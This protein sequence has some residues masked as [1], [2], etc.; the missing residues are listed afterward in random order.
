MN[1]IYKL[2][3][4]KRRNELVVVS[5]ITAGMGKEK[6]T[7]QLADLVALSP[8]RKLLGTLTPV[9]LLTGLIAGLLPAMAL[10]ADLPTGGQI[11]GGQGSI[12]TSGNQMTIHQQTQNMAANWHSFDIGKNNTVQ[13][14]Q[15]NSSSVALNR[16]TGASGSQIMGTLK[17]NGQVFI[18]NPNGVL[19]GKNARVDVGGL[20]ASTKNI[21]T[22][23]FMK[24]Q[25]TLSGSGNPGA[26]VVNQGSLTTSKGGYIVLAGER[27]SNSGTVTTPSGKTILAAGK[28]VT[29]QLDNGGLTSVSVNGSVVNALVENQGLISA[30]NGQVYLTAKGQDMLLNTVVNNSGTVEAKGLANRGGEIVLN[31]GDSGVVSQSGHLLADSQTGQGGK[32]TLE[33]QNI[34]LAGGSLTTATG[35]TGGG[36]VYV[37]GGW[38]GQDSHIKNASKVVM[39]KAATVDVSATENGNGGTAVLWS[40]DYTNFR[41]TVLAK[42]GAKSGDGGRVETSSHRN[43]QAS[44]AVDASARAGHGGEW[45]LDP[46]DVTIVGAGADTGIDSATADGT[47]IF[48]PTA[49]GGQILNSSIVNQL[50]AGTSVTVKTSGTDTDGETGN[51][52]VNANI[53]KTAGTD[54]KL[55]LLADNNIST[56]DNVSIGATTGKLN[57]DLLAGNT[58]NNASISLGKFINISLNGGDLLADAGNSASGVS[59][60]FMNNGKIKGGNVTLNLS[61]GLGGY[62]YNV[63][64]DNDLTINGSVTGSTGWGAV[65]GFTAGGKLAMN[66]PGSISLQANDPGNGG[67]RVLISG[68]KGVTLNAAAGTVTLNAAKAA[69]N[70]VNIT[71]GNGAVSITNMVQDGSNGMTLTNANISS[72]DGIVLN[73]TTF[74]GQAVVMSGVNLT[75]GGDVD[76]T[77]LA[78]NLTTGGLGAASSSGVQLSG[79]NISST[80]GNITLTGTAGT[81]V[82]HP[83]ISSLQVSNS[84]FTT[85]NALTLNGTTETTTGVKVTGSTLSAAT[86]NVNGVARVQGTG[87]SLATSQLLGGLADLTNVSLSSAG[88]AAGAQNVLDNSIV[89]DANRD[90]L[91]A[92]RIEN[93]TSV[94][95]NGTA[96]FDD[97]AKS[98]KGWTHDYSSVDTPNGGWIF[99]NTSVTAGGDVN[100]KGVAFTNA[101]VTVSNGSL[102]LDN[103]GAVPLTGTTVT[104]N[105]GAV[106]VHSGGGNIDL[107]K[108]NISAKRDITLKTDNG[109]VLI[110]GAN[111]TVKAN[112]TSSDGD[113]MITGN[114]GTSMGVRLVNANLTSIN[115]SI[116]GSAIG[117]SNDDMASFGAVSLFGAD[118]FH[119]ANTGHGEMNG[120]VN[121]YLDLTRNGAI[122]IGQIFAG[123]DTNVVFDGSFDIKGDAFTTGAKPS[124]TYDIFFN[125]GSSSITFKGG[126]SSLTSCSH[127]VYTRFSAYS[128]THTTNFILDGADFVFNVTAGT[129]PHQG[130]SMLGT[131]EFNKYTSGFAFSGNGNAQLNI[132]TSSQEEG[133]Y[134]NR[135]TNKDLLG[136][137]SLNVTNDIGDAIVMLGHTAVNLVNATITGT[138]GT[139]AG[140]RLESTDKSNVS[141]GNNTITGISKTGSGIK[142]IGNNITLSN[143]TLNGT[144]GNGSGVVLTGGSNYTLDGAS[145][146]GT[147]AAGSGIAVNGTLTVNNGTVVKGLATGGGNGVTVSGDLVTDSGDGIS[148]SGTASSGDGI[149]VDGDTTL[150]NA[151]LNGGADS[152]VGVNIAGNLTTDSSTQVS[153]HADSG[154]GVNL[155]AALTGASVK[156]SSDT[157]TGVQLADNAVVT[158]AV[159]NG[160][161]ASGDGVTFTGNVKMDDTSAAKLNASSTSGT[162]LKLADNANVSI[163]TITKVTQEKKD[164]DG[165]PVLDA[166]GNPETE[167]ITTQAPVTTPVTLTGTSE[168]GS[169]I[170]TEGNVSISGI[171]LNGSTTADTGTGVSLGGNL[172]IADD[173]S[174]VTAGATGNGTA[175]VVNNASIHSDGYTDSGKDFVINASVSGNGTAIKTQGS[176]QLD[177]VVLNGNATGGGTAV[178]LGGQ[179]SG[180]NITGTS[181]SGTAVRVTDGAGVDGSAVKGHSDSGTGLQVSG[182]ASLN[183]SDLSGTTQTGT[184]AAVTGSLTAD[185]SSQV[186][187]SA[188]QDGGTGVTVDGSVTGATVTGDAT[189]GDAVR[190]ADGSQFT[191]ADIKGT[192]VTGSGIKTQ[193]N[194][195]LEGGT[196]LAGGSQQGAALDVSGTLNHDPDSSVTTTPDNTGSVIGNENI[197]E[198]IPVV[199][200]VP[201]E[202][203]DTDKPTVPSE[204]DQKPGGDTDKPTVPSEPDQKPGGDTDKPTVPS[205][206]DH[207][208]EH[209][210]NQSHNASLRKQAEVNSL[211]QGAAN[212][213]VTQMNRASQDGFHAAGSPSVPVSGYQPAEQTVD[214]SLC[215]GSDCQSE[216]LDA[217]TPSQGR[218]KASGR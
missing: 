151:T 63:N 75:T 107:T 116:N 94:E 181:D 49:S 176:S 59:L 213:Q 179:V 53:I 177:E 185:T 166:D 128:A 201:D 214:I 162:G 71:S 173:I 135:L 174:G 217:G 46:T 167:T 140:F 143:G 62:A 117:G 6:T 138:S 84:T 159:L 65:L 161:S 8:F 164:S 141:L 186:T 216:S 18:L 36:E 77:G 142:L 93:M 86:L 74:W 12:S 67:G 52:T 153:G 180:A 90:T 92:K 108:G 20:V 193:G 60:T 16:V 114:S 110:S 85:N 5:E 155:G 170:A 203:G 25:Y 188:T 145:V 19:F 165:N 100:L 152:G 47:D 15:P 147:A 121:N 134:L 81:D 29:L 89:N 99:N 169:G 207:N 28:T 3:F 172:T 41:G 73:G 9:A 38:Q 123:G 197:H 192:S 98:D 87:F 189:S 69:T 44:G 82:S 131:I 40:D 109:T 61:R 205:E 115:M 76:I 171:V 35:K 194:V 195:S 191:G 83:S 91:L 150:T 55:T 175:L 45:L 64:A 105:D 211:R 57:L 72:K 130:L 97:S 103:G 149:K 202:G 148:I 184:G 124:S 196:Q 133:I 120:Y 129:A 132:H 125:N 80:G 54:A 182:N 127:G 198:V 112:I 31:G 23:D 26:Q 58:T 17:A 102:T 33:G 66:S 157:G 208:Q 56:G 118:E 4:D 199:P 101:T 113:I 218:A 34:H 39:D 68:D 119:V 126:K 37:G 1:K 146:T 200:P 14:V 163:Q 190:I 209:D 111:A 27:V 204:P 178:E 212:A 7:G 187:G 48:T 154:T 106:S 43:L 2:K 51:I 158:E 24:G 88:S 13:F 70:G 11:V 78:K 139:G 42:G 136:N 10:A 122:V 206:P 156:G 21:S 104:V 22:T 144:S 137:F 50:N 96:I 183:N 215:D 30:T 32:I 168:Q 95:M 79:S 210:H 160:T